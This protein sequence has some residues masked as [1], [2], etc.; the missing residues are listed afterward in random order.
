[1][2][3][4]ECRAVGCNLAASL[5]PLAYRENV[6]SLSLFC[7]HYFG[8]CSSE[9]TELVPI[10]YSHERPTRYCN[11]LHDFSVTIPTYYKDAYAKSFF[12]YAARLKN[13]L[14]VKC[15]PMTY[16]LNHFQSRIKP[17]F[18]CRHSFIH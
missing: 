10:T 16:D 2:F 14:P 12:P 15:F 6:V 11:S 3:E 9:P 13:Y 4:C 5:E 7:W 1:M 8:S 17:V 18:S